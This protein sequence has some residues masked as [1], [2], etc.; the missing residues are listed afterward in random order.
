MG[1]GTDR[2]DAGI[3]AAKEVSRRVAK[4]ARAAIPASERDRKSRAIC[5]EVA[6]AFDARAEARPRPF[7]VALYAA[8]R[9]EVA[10]DALARHAY[11]CAWRVCFPAMVRSSAA[12][13]GAGAAM[14][15]FAVSREM[16]EAR[17]APFLAR[18]ARS[19]DEA[20]LARAGLA[21]V[22]PRDIDA[23]AVPLVAFDDGGGRVGYGGGN[24]DRYLPRLRADA[25]AVGVAFEEQRVASV[26]REGHDVPLARVVY[27]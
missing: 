11:D 10:L 8:L 1:K 15:F 5:S 25:L 14:A 27:A 7:V 12:P 26:P 17:A 20:A 2:T 22:P 3:A 16:F 24:Y 13:D 6:R 9:D 18:P 23:M 4:A 21:P 19:C